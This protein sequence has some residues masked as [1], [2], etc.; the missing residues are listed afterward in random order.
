MGNL[1]R[2]PVLIR[3]E[4]GLNQEAVDQ[5]E[6]HTKHNNSGPQ[7]TCGGQQRALQISDLLSSSISLNI[8]YKGPHRR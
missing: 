4:A 7:L 8:T 1:Q 6:H 2:L 3:D 5:S